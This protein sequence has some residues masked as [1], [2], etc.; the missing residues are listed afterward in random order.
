MVTI[1]KHA[2]MINEVFSYY[3]RMVNME[4]LEHLETQ[5]QYLYTDSAEI[6]HKKFD[7]I[8][9]IYNYTKERLQVDDSRIRFLFSDFYKRGKG[10]SMLAA[11]AILFDPAKGELDIETY[12]TRL[13]GLTEEERIKEYLRIIDDQDEAGLSY[14]GPKTL[15]EFIQ[16]LDSSSLDKDICWNIL[17]VFQNQ[18]AYFD[19]VVQIYIDTKALFME[20]KEQLDYLENGFYEYWVKVQKTKEI[21][22]LFKECYKV[23][24]ENSNKGCIVYM[25][26]FAPNQLAAVLDEE[27]H[28][29]EDII[30][31]GVLMDERL[32]LS[33][34]ALTK[35]EAIKIGK[36]IGDKSKLDILDFI[37]KKPA[38]GKEI[39]S[40][41]GLST[42]T[43]SYHM[44]GLSE[45]GFVRTSIEAGRIFYEMDEEQIRKKLDQLKEFF[46]LMNEDTNSIS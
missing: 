36:L 16:Y 26:I 43:I 5:I 19:E 31:I 23:N 13:K 30:Y 29:S 24:W 4:S 27:T 46:T 39:A 10:F 37:S 41:M 40:A 22:E 35:N 2:N 15:E 28:K 34:Q 7:A 3:N 8:K 21:Q 38:F 42:A 20:C 32:A 25:S 1:M 12:R 18:E 11:L 45:E 33:N 17:R 14:Q 9:Y 44:N 6:Y